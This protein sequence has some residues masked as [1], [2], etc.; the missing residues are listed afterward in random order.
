MNAWSFGIGLL[1]VVAATSG[2]ITH[3][4][5]HDTSA[6]AA[7]VV[8]TV[9]GATVITTAPPPALACAGGYAPGGGTN[10]GACGNVTKP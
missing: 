5:E 6:P 2:C 3:V 9:P 4:V 10:F 8:T 1:V 7:T